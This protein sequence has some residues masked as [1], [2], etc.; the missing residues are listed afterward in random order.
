MK[1]K[2]FEGHFTGGQKYCCIFFPTHPLHRHAHTQA[3]AHTIFHN[4]LGTV[5][6]VGTPNSYDNPEGQDTAF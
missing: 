4:I 5:L 2:M 1:T 3:H 6:L